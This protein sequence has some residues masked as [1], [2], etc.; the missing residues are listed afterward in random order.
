CPACA[1]APC[2]RRTHGVGW[3]SVRARVRRAGAQCFAISLAPDSNMQP[4]SRNPSR[5][6]LPT[7]MRYM[8]SSQSLRDLRQRQSDLEN[9]YDMVLEAL[10]RKMLDTI[11]T[12]FD[13]HVVASFEDLESQEK[14]VEADIIKNMQAIF[15]ATH[16]ERLQKVR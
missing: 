6:A 8:E 13:P 14:V 2:G 15:V 1:A 16:R 7:S 4:G 5:V 10:E 3:G 11:S 9:T 12:A